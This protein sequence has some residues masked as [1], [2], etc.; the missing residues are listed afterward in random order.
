MTARAFNEA[1]L[2]LEEALDLLESPR[3]DGRRA[4]ENSRGPGVRQLNG[5]SAERPVVVRLS[6]VA[7]EVVSWLAPGIL[8]F[9][10]FAIWEGDP[11][12]GKSTLTLDLAA[13]IT[14]GESVLGAAPQVPRDVVLV[15]FEDGLADTV[16][17]RIDALGGDPHRVVAFRAVALGDGDER[18]PTLPGDV[19]HLRAIIEENGAALV[20]ID[21][22]GAA[23]G[24][25]TDSHKDASV[26]R[27]TARLARLAEDTGACVLGVRHLIKGVAA[28]ALRAG[29]GSIAFVASARVAMVVSLHPDDA[30]K[31]Q[32]ERRRVLA[33]VKNNLAPY[34]TSR[35]F[36]LCQPDGHDH[37]RIHWLGETLLSADDLNAAAT[38]SVPEERNAATERS[39]WLREVLA[40]GSLDSKEIFRLGRE[41]GYP[42]RSLRRVAHAIGVRF[43]REGTGR[44]HRT[45]WDLT[46]TPATSATPARQEDLAGVAEVGAPRRSGSGGGA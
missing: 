1:A 16:R 12:T 31:P 45:L 11:G 38:A 15:T 10:K 36:E 26:R 17:P 32:H 33:C 44:S 22:L 20:I 41:A 29:G 28:N 27:V 43:Q 5:R 3:A 21:P 37:P 42:E 8:P 13:R 40:S 30:E 24:E 7:P 35:M 39:G 14:R 18:E 9:G 25:G 23:I 46:V 34:P 2:T 4:V 6:D 19:E